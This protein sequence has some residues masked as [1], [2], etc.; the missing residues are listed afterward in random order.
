MSSFLLQ[1]FAFMFCTFLLGLLLGWLVWRFG[2]SS[3]QALTSMNSEVDFWRSNLEQC[4]LELGKEQN[5]LAALHEER[6]NL[7]KRLA[8]LEEQTNL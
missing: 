8:S 6:T 3:R 2:G 5:N 1:I 4:R 7:K